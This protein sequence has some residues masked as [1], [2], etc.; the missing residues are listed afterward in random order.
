MIHKSGKRNLII[1]V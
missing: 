1:I